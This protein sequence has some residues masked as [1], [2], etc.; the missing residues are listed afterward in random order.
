MFILA[1][2]TQL[3]L[4]NKLEELLGSRNVYY[5]PPSFVQI[6]YPAIVYSLDDIDIKKAD[7]KSYISKR[8]YSIT[9]IDKTP[10]NPVID[11]ILDL[12]YANYNRNFISD[13]LHHDVV[14]LYF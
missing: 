13:N 8:R 5:Q 9:V 14:I 4:Q 2:N 7:N 1:K 11:K 12:E 3:D 10:D 6:K